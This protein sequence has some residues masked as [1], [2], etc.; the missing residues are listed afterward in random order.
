MRS[1]A[2]PELSC[3]RSFVLHDI[4]AAMLPCCLARSL[5]SWLFVSLLAPP[6]S[7]FNDDNVWEGS[8]G[9]ST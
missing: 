9:C 3:P 2:L 4:I 6:S 5:A 1:E 8:R 7:V